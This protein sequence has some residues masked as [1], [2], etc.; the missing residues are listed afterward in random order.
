LAKTPAWLRRPVSLTG[1]MI[2][3][4]NP[5]YSRRLPVLLTGATSLVTP[6][7]FSCKIKKPPFVGGR[8]SLQQK[9]CYV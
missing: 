5:P 7:N 9:Q 8:N 6:V 3:T 1:G 4:G 2:T